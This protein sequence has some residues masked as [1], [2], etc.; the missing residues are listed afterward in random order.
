MSDK[1]YAYPH[2]DQTVIHAP[3]ECY[4][5]DRYAST[6]QAERA[7]S[8]QPF[9]PN[10]ANGWSGN[11]AWKRGDTAHH[12][13]ATFVV[14]GRDIP[15]AQT[16]IADHSRISFGFHCKLPD[17]H[18]GPCPAYARWWMKPWLWAKTGVWWP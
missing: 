9:T 3:G 6:L 8:G 14:G 2:C 15:V 17:G 11:V 13:G 18:D 5:C 10:E 16:F 4:Y 7:A 12:M 1:E